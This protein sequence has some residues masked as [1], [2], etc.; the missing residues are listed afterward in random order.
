MGGVE[1][2]PNQALL[3]AQARAENHGNIGDLA[4]GAAG[5]GQGDQLMHAP[6]IRHVSVQVVDILR[7][8]GGDSKHLCHIHDGAA[9][10]GDDARHAHLCVDA[11]S[12]SKDGVDHVVGGLCRAEFLAED[13]R[14]GAV[15]RAKIGLIAGIGEDQVMGGQLKRPGKGL[16]VRK[17]VNGRHQLEQLHIGVLL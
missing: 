7:A 16:K 14:T 4:T 15:R 1:R 8:V 17:F 9:A 10:D 3:G 11:V 6:E 13:D 12:L 5:G 2:V